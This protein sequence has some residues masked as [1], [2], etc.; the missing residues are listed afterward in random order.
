M[1]NAF[2]MRFISIDKP[3]NGLADEMMP[4]NCVLIEIEVIQKRATEKDML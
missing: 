4:L 1:K 3:L 2:D